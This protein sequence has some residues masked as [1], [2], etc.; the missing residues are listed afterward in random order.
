[1]KYSVKIQAGEHEYLQYFVWS[2]RRSPNVPGNCKERVPSGVK[3]V[4]VRHLQARRNCNLTSGD[5][6]AGVRNQV[7]GVKHQMS[8]VRGQVA[9]VRWLV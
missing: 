3:V 8:G 6:V 1:M 9:V 7:S 4:C 5:R 2:S